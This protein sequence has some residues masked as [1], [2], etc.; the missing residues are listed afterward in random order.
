MADGELSRSILIQGEI[1]VL[2]LPPSIIQSG[3]GIEVS[4][5]EVDG[6]DLWVMAHQEGFNRDLGWVR[7]GLCLED[8][9][10]KNLMCARAYSIYGYQHTSV[11]ML[12][13]ARAV[14]DEGVKV[15]TLQME[16]M[17]RDA[18]ERVT[19]GKSHDFVAVWRRLPITELDED[20]N[21]RFRAR[22]HLMTRCAYEAGEARLAAIRASIQEAA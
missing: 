22:F 13:P 6:Y 20:K 8:V 19:S 14:R 18:I 4:K 7:N 21:L 15:F 3:P 5:E 9:F 12:V 17:F 1:P 16:S 2:S 10:S 11:S